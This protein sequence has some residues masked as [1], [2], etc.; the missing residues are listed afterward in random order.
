LNFWRFSLSAILFAPALI[1]LWQTE[2][3]KDENIAET[4]TQTSSLQNPDMAP[5]SREERSKSNRAALLRGGIELG[6]YT[7]LGFGFQAIGLETTTASRSAF[8]LY[9]NVKVS[10]SHCSQYSMIS[11]LSAF[12]IVLIHPF[13]HH[14]SAISHF[15]QLHI[16]SL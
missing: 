6:L 9:L 4:L 8:L 15:K 11:S 3:H 2:K 7:F 5:K 12:S 16:F 1:S 13:S 10:Y 14:A